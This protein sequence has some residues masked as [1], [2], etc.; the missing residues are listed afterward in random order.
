MQPDGR[1]G[2]DFVETGKFLPVPIWSGLLDTICAILYAKRPE[3]G[4]IWKLP[5]GQENFRL[6]SK[7]ILTNLGSFAK[8]INVIVGHKKTVPSTDMEGTV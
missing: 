6:W 7:C 1:T 5:H 4:N 3:T 2:I 8:I